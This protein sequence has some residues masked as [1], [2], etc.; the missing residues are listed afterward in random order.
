MDEESLEIVKATAQG[1]AEGTTETVLR[2]LLAPLV[3]RRQEN[4]DIIRGRRAER[5]VEILRRMYAML[6]D[7]NVPPEWIPDKTLVPLLTNAS[8]E[9]DPDMQQ[10]WAA[11]LANAAAG[12]QGAEVMPAFAQV[13]SELTPIGAKMLDELAQTSHGQVDI[14]W[15]AEAAGWDLSDATVSDQVNVHIDISSG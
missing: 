7:A 15:L 2:A 9:D 5:Q 4:A 14:H 8:L 12:E 6:D 1:V 13:L 3:E 10:R 11:L